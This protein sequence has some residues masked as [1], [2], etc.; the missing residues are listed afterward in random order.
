[1]TRVSEKEIT[2]MNISV[3]K[4]KKKA[5]LVELRSDILYMEMHGINYLSSN[6]IKCLHKYLYNIK[7]VTFVP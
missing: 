7:K 1:M 6:D 3:E 2:E 5:K 4:I